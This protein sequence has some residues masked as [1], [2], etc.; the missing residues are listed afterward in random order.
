MVL[1]SLQIKYQVS[2][3]PN[4]K[5]KVPHADIWTF[6]N[7]LIINEGGTCLECIGSVKD[8]RLHLGICDSAA[9]IMPRHSRVTAASGAAGPRQ[10][11]LAPFRPLHCRRNAARLTVPTAHILS[12]VQSVPIASNPRTVTYFASVRTPGSAVKMKN[13]WIVVRLYAWIAL[14]NMAMGV[15]VSKN[16]FYSVEIQSRSFVSWTTL[17]GAVMMQ[18][19]G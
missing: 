19:Y 16:T 1:Q 3:R 7:I 15:G 10:F 5:Y 18:L 13:V 12:M 11:H 2:I 8:G 6:M 4:K 9:S 17:C 14:R